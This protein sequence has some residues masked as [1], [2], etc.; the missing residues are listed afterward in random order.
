MSN[1][2]PESNIRSRWILQVTGWLFFAYL[3]YAQLIPAFDYGLGVQMGTQEPASQVTEVGV[4]Y[5]WAFATADLVIYAPL[6]VAGLVGHLLRRTWGRTVLAAAFGIT[7]YWPIVSLAAVV[8]ASG[9][10]GWNLPNENQYWLVLPLITLWGAW[11]LWQVMRDN[12]PNAVSNRYE[13]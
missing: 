7:I 2:A 13:R 8:S 12:S 1:Q 5:W 9:A 4:A 3:V 6:F 10:P 11:G